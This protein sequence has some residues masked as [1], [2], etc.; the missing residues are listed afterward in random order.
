[1][2]GR[3]VLA[4]ASIVF[5]LLFYQIM[6]TMHAAAIASAPTTPA[7]AHARGRGA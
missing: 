1:M 5:V 3:Y 4:L 6:L 2:C 7:I